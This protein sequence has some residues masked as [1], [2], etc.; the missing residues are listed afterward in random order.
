VLDRA[1]LHFFNQSGHY[2]FQEYPRETADLIVSFIKNAN[3]S[4]S[5]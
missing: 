1:E 2:V 3:A 4:G 5:H